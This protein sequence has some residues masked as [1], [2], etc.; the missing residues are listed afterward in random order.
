MKTITTKIVSMAAA[1]VLV[2][3]TASALPQGY[4]GDSADISASATVLDWG[5]CGDNVTWKLD[6]GTL[7]ISGTGATYDY[8]GSSPFEYFYDDIKNVV[9]GSGITRIG[10]CLFECCPMESV[11]IPSTVRSIG[12]YAFTA[13]E[14]LRIVTIPKGV[15][16]IEESAFDCSHIRSISLPDT[17]TSI[18]KQ[19]FRGT[20]LK[21]VNI[22]GSVKTMQINAFLKCNDLEIVNVASGVTEI[23]MHAFY[24]CQNLTTVKLPDTVSVIGER[25]FYQCPIKNI[26]FPNSMRQI[27]KYAFEESGIESVNIPNGVTSIGENAF[28]KCES[29]KSVVISGNGKTIGKSAFQYCKSLKSVVLPD[30]VETIGD[31]AFYSCSNLESVR[32][33]AKLKTIGNSA[34]YFCRG[35]KNVTIPNT[36][37]SIGDGA[38]SYSGLTEIS[39]PD[40]VTSLGAAALSDCYHLSKVNIPKSINEIPSVMFCSCRSLTS[41]SIPSNIKKIGGGAFEE[42]NS[43]ESVTIPSSVTEIEDEAFNCCDNLKRIYVPDSVK[44]IGKRVLGFDNNHDIEDFK[45]ICHKGSAAETYAG[46]KGLDCIIIDRL[47]GKNRYETAVNISQNAFRSTGYVVLASGKD[48]ADALAGVP[49]AWAYSCPILLTDNKTLPAET[50]AEIKRLGANNVIILG[51]TGAV[52]EDVENVL[53]SNNLTTKRIAGRTRFETAVEISKE[54]GKRQHKANSEIF[55]VYGHGFADALSIG[56]IAANNCDSIIYLNKN[57]EIDKATKEYLASIKGTVKKAYVIGGEGVISNDMMKKAAKACGLT[58]ATRIAGKNRYE[59]CTKVNET[60]ANDFAGQSVFIAKGTDFPDALAGGVYAAM[61]TSPVLLADG[62]LTD[63]HVHKK[64][65]ENQKITDIYAL[66]GK[67][68]VPDSIVTGAATISK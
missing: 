38:F 55:F 31:Y 13:T 25:A 16:S 52:S 24:C 6:N 40:S 61:K 39:F 63:V 51:G 57:G 56:S 50:L 5:E 59:T 34:F 18:G 33:P 53:R 10:N 12:E 58:K 26:S 60:F 17:L 47:A 45:L 65:L 37:K 36:V 9:I 30:T 67:A 68:A 1:I 8:A 48:Y 49:L 22:P 19:A 20:K 66:G 3:G 7:T 28:N 41:I 42:C 44:T 14:E 32:M 54:L 15:T 35:L 64:Y 21:S 43:L 27:D 46:S 2:F 29:L 11:S 62:S 23:G 4:I